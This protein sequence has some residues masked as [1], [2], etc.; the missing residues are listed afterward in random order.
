MEQDTVESE[1]VL[2][3]AKILLP[4]LPEGA[5]GGG[6]GSCFPQGVDQFGVSYNKK[7]LDGW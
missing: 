4:W 5:G 1:D 2:D 6:G 7:L 3:L